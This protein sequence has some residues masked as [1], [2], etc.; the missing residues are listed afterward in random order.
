VTRA[1]KEETIRMCGLVYFESTIF[2]AKLLGQFNSRS[3][4]ATHKQSDRQ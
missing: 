2:R 4:I 3:L 1:V